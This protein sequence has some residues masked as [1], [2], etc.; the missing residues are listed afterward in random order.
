MISKIQREA[1]DDE[2]AIEAWNE[3]RALGQPL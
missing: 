2:R 1:L 3:R